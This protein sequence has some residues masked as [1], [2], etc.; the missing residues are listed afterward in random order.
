MSADANA[1]M[2][3]SSMTTYLREGN[4]RSLHFMES[5]AET[6]PGSALTQSD[7]GSKIV[8]SKEGGAA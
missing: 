3:L 1:S 2:G 7:A 4:Y 6:G 8:G 5:T